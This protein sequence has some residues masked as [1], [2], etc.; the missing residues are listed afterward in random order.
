MIGTGLMHWYGIHSDP[1]RFAE[2]SA[3]VRALCAS[4]FAAL[5]MAGAMDGIALLVAFYDGLFALFYWL[6]LRGK[7]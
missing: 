5:Y 1:H 3:S 6:V 2:L 7:E 4:V